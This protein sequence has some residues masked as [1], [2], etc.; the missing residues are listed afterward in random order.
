VHPDDHPVMNEIL[1]LLNTF[2]VWIYILL[3]LVGIYYLQKFI[4]ALNEWHGTIFGLERDNAQRRLNEAVTVLILSLLIAAGEFFVTTFVIPTVPGLQVLSTPTL[5]V[6]TTPTTTLAAV[7]ATLAPGGTVSPGLETATVTPTLNSGQSS[8]G[9]IAGKLEFTAPVNGQEISGVVALKGKLVV[10][11]FGFYKYEY[12]K[13]G[14]NTWV[15]IAAGNEI[16]ADGSLGFWDVS[17][18]PI[19]DYLL[20]IIVYDNKGQ[21]LPAC[22]I[23]VKVSTPAASP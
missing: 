23:S 1:R 6:L 17:L 9:C 20:H 2:E 10:E 14:S 18:L 11:N 22:A 13:P 5:D 12:S 3:G 19:G 16:K 15:T 21:Q 8:N 7:P 4:R